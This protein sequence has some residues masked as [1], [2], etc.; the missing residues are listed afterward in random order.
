MPIDANIVAVLVR[1]QLGRDVLVSAREGASLLPAEAGID[2][3]WIVAH[4]PGS[5]RGL[6]CWGDI[7]DRVRPP[8]VSW[9]MTRW[10]DAAEVLRTSEDTLARRRQAHD[11][12]RACHFANAEELYAWWR[13]LS[14]RPPRT[15]RRKGDRP[16]VVESD[17]DWRRVQAE[18]RRKK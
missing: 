1:A 7:L 16:P 4:V 15:A 9:P 3:A 18:F 5:P 6:F 8:D 12:M 2:A 11:P 14:A 10:R 13:G 17:I